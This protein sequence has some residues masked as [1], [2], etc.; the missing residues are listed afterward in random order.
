MFKTIRISNVINLFRPK[1]FLTWNNAEKVF[2]I[3]FKKWQQECYNMVCK[4]MGMCS[5]KTYF[6]I[7]SQIYFILLLHVPLGHADKNYLHK[8]MSSTIYQ[9]K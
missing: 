8:T 9:R 4:S 2:Y 1:K 6:I 3:L 7:Y 5:I